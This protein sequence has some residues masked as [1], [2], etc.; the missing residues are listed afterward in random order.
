MSP[1]ECFT[2]HSMATPNHSLHHM[3]HTYIIIQPNLRDSLVPG[4][5]SSTINIKTSVQSLLIVAV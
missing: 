3:S 4:L 5:C 1:Q 2:G